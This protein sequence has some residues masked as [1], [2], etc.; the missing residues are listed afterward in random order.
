MQHNFFGIWV[1]SVRTHGA[2]FF[3]ASNV[4]NL[5]RKILSTYYERIAIKLTTK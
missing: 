2:S 4:A 5:K 1:L 3:S